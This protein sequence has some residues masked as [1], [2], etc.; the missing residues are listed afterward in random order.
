[1]SEDT[2]PLLTVI[3][4]I[5]G[6]EQLQM[7]K[8]ILPYMEKSSQRTMALYIKVL[9]LN[10][11]RSFYASPSD[12]QAYSLEAEPV[13]TLEMLQD[14]RNFC[15]TLQRNTIDQC[16]NLFQM[17]TLF[18]SMDGMAGDSNMLM[19]LLSPEQQSLFETYQSM[20]SPL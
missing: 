8:A 18:K 15:G 11:I 16:I 5:A 10:N 14:I 19:S 12:M 9:E 13:S 4:Q 1:M 6:G 7:L 20:A 3:D 17:A 2:S